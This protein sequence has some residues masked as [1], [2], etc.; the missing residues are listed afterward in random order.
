MREI[1][2]VK[3][4]ADSNYNFFLDLQYS[5]D[6]SG[7]DSGLQN[8]PQGYDGP[9]RVAGGQDITQQDFCGHLEEN[10]AL[11]IL[12]DLFASFIPALTVPVF[13]KLCEW[14]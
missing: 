12:V 9:V 13:K 4:V 7:V 10:A 8:K 2:C 5:Y 6:P 11:G 3:D 14:L 1:R